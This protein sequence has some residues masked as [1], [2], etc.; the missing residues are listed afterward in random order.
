[1]QHRVIGYFAPPA[2]RAAVD[3]LLSDSSSVRSDSSAET[4]SYR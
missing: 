2:M 4:I 1:V 3:R